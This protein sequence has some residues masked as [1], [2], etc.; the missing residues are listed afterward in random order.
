VL[1]IPAM[2]PIGIPMPIC[3]LRTGKLSHAALPCVIADESLVPIE[4]V[5]RRR[6]EC[7]D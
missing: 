1:T 3:K 4:L 6:S 2:I 7:F 5:R